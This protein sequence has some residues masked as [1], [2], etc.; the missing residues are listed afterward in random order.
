MTQQ[1]MFNYEL[2]V[3][4]SSDIPVQGIKSIFKKISEM[5]AKNCNGSVK[6]IEYL[7]VRKLAYKIKKYPKAR[8]YILYFTTKTSNISNISSYLNIN[9]GVV[10]SLIT[11]ID[12]IPSSQSMIASQSIDL[13]PVDDKDYQKL[14]E[15]V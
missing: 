4:V 8:F 2:F 12:S 10:R 5:I 11:K 3:S 9:D 13:I 14:C 7:G 1:L 6:K 15:N